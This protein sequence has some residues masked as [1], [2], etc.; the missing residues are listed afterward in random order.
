MRSYLNKLAGVLTLVLFS[1]PL[2][3]QDAMQQVSERSYTLEFWILSTIGVVLLMGIFVYALAIRSLAE[4]GSLAQKLKN[5]AEKLNAIWLFAAPSAAIGEA[6]HPVLSHFDFTTV[7]ILGIVDVSMLL[8]LLYLR[9][10]FNQLLNIDKVEVIEENAAIENITRVLT[11]AVPLEMEHSIL[12]DHDYDGIQELDNKLPPWWLWSFYASIVFAVIYMFHYHVFDTGKSIHENL[13]IEIENAEIAKADYL[14]K[15]AL[16]V[17]ENSVTLMLDG[18]NLEK[19]RKIFSQ[20]C[21]TCHGTEGQGLVGP[22]FADNYSLYGGTVKDVFKVIKY[23]AKRGM[24]SWQEELNPLEMQQVASFIVSLQGTNPP[25]QLPPDGELN[26]GAEAK[27]E[28]EAPTDTVP[29]DQAG[30]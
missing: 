21:A 20:S 12:M 6:A 13:A 29:A 28:I 14:K 7:L 19:G 2:F 27:V 3:A 22:N 4:S 25:N 10:I 24:I 11:S 17:D 15:L 5:K 30:D 16:S 8:L 9:R 26:A 23:G 18:T 1:A